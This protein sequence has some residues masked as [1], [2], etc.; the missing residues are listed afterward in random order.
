[1]R[2]IKTF[3][4]GAAIL[5]L[6]WATLFC[7]PGASVY[8]IDLSSARGRVPA[9]QIDHAFLL[10]MDA[11][12]PMGYSGRLA[13]DGARRLEIVV[14]DGPMDCGYDGTQCLGWLRD[15]TIHV[16][17]PAACAWRSRLVHEMI[18]WH[19]LQSSFLAMFPRR[20]DPRLY[21]G[22]L[23]SVEARVGAIMIEEYCVEA[24]PRG[25]A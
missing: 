20:H 11:M 4:A 25:Q 10:I 16:V 12:E 23:G 19:E 13:R 8:G 2:E 14:E 18:H 17:L 1:M 9:A 15:D 5:G 6:Y 24:V 22:D 3:V 7:Q 21:G